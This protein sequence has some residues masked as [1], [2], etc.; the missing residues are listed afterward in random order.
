VSPQNETKRALVQGAPNPAQ[1]REL[2]RKVAEV[3]QGMSCIRSN[4]PVGH[5]YPVE[6]D[7]CAEEFRLPPTLA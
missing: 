5:W 2:P 3:G 7:V 4:L 1:C 6:F